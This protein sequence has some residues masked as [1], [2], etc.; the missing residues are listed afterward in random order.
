VKNP[1]Y[2]SMN[3]AIDTKKKNKNKKTHVLHQG[4]TKVQKGVVCHLLAL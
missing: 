1:E 2:L 3:L 4:S